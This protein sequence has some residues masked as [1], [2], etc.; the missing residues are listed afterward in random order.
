MEKEPVFSAIF[1]WLGRT[2][3]FAR[4]SKKLPGKWK[5]YEYYVD[6]K[7]ELLH[8]EEKML[9]ENRQGFEIEFNAEGNF[10]HSSSLPLSII[11]NLE[12]GEWSV[13]RNFITLMH[14]KNF[15]DNVEFQF[16]FEKGNLKLLKKD[17]FGNIEFFG[18]FKPIRENKVK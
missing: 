12:N 3:L 15:R 18:F 9:A 8:F 6:V 7:D 2:E 4:P 14:P 17:A 5:L 16:A 10:V 11:Q 13:S 1:K